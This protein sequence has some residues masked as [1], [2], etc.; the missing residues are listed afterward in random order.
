[1]Q[2]VTELPGVVHQFHQQLGFEGPVCLPV[3]GE[4]VRGGNILG[5]A[6][7][8]EARAGRIEREVQASCERSDLRLL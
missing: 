8:E 1:M 2:V 5:S 3:T 6:A 7:A 4:F